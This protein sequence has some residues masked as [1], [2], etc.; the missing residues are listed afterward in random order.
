[1]PTATYGRYF[2]RL[3]PD[4]PPGPWSRFAEIRAV[5]QFETTPTRFTGR[6]Q[7]VEKRVI[8]AQSVPHLWTDAN[9]ARPAREVKIMSP[10]RC[11][12]SVLRFSDHFAVEGVEM[13]KQAC[14][15]VA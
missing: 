6:I 15:L 14:A 9:E 13:H 2:G 5:P 10:E 11:L 7:H 1:M 12:Q 4:G 8:L 3:S